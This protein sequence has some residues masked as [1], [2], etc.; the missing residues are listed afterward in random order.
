MA[1]LYNC[2]RTSTI[3]S[4]LYSTLGCIGHVVMKEILRDFP[5]FT[6]H[7]KNDIVKFYDDDLKLFLIASLRRV[8]YLKNAAP[9]VLTHLAYVMVG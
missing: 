9:E 7:L 3:K 5:L 1:F 6:K 4:K 8:D 2:R